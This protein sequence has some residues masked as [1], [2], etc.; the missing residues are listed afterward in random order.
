[1]K[2]LTLLAEGFEETE[3]IA[4]IDVLRR[5]DFDLRI[6]SISD[7]LEVTGSHRIKVIA[8]SLLKIE[9]TSDYDMVF[10]PGGKGVDV[11]LETKD[12][13]DIVKD[14][15]N[16]NKYI[17]AICAAPSVLEKAGIL[18]GVQV[19]A[20]PSTQE[21]LKSAIVKNTDVVADGKII[22]GRGVGAAL[23]FAL[24]IVEIL[25]SKDAAEKLRK[26]IVYKI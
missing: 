15:A 1:M 2:I 20:F 9:D 7:K 18:K 4:V 23:D 6:A 22:T 25:K 11:F 14:F 26:I 5:A 17:A 16:K 24:K 8:D 12:V 13:L 19:T 21:I 10:L 3:A